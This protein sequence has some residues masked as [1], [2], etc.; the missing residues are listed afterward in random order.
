M[1]GPAGQQL[2]T[3]QTKFEKDLVLINYKV[4]I[5][6]GI[7]KFHFISNHLIGEESDGRVYVNSTKVSGMKEHITIKSIHIMLSNKK[8]LIAKN[9]TEKVIALSL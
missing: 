6:S 8:K 1:D 9:Y 3:N 7:S 5:I 4:G 2:V